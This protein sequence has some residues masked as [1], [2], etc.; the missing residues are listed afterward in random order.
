MKTAAVIGAGSMLGRQLIERL[1]EHGVETFTVGRGPGDDIRFDLLDT[2]VSVPAGLGADV[3]FH[4][5]A[6]FAGDSDEGLREN[7]ALNA[8]SAIAVGDLVRQLGAPVLVY[9]GSAS[10]DPALDPAHFT[11]YG[12]TKAIAEQV[13]Q[14][15]MAKHGGRFCSLRFTQLYDTN[16]RCCHH[17]PWFGRIIAYASKGLDMRMPPSLGVRNLLH[18]RDAADLMIRSTQAE[19]SADLPITHP[20]SLTWQQVADIA[21]DVFDLGGRQVEAPEKSPFRTIHFADGRPAFDLLGLA[22]AI[23]MRN[24]IDM[25]KSAGTAPAFGP[26]DI[27]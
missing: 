1:Q 10:S 3:V 20:E 9:A 27:T 13:L 16:G 15:T 23:G 2:T 5:A 4:C 6:G 11:S 17:Q 22:P 18:V 12:L 7:F 25:I 14:W 26:M 21:Y 8:T 24:G 19:I